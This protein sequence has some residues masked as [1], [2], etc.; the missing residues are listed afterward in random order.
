MG[1]KAEI[2]ELYSTLPLLN[3]KEN[4]ESSYLAAGI[5]IDTPPIWRL[6]DYPGY[7]E[8]IFKRVPVEQGSFNLDDSANCSM[9][10]PYKRYEIP[11]ILESW[12]ETTKYIAANFNKNVNVSIWSRGMHAEGY[13]AA[14]VELTKII[15]LRENILDSSLKFHGMIEDHSLK[16]GDEV[17]FVLE[18]DTAF[19]LSVG[20]DGGLLP[21]G[22]KLA[23]NDG[24]QTHVG[25]D[26][27]TTFFRKSGL[28]ITGWN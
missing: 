3:I 20:C 4:L 26:N 25:E 6:L 7:Y 15:E 17:Y 9:D 11:H 2:L 16:S 27:N 18:S 24:G 1:L 22:R 19:T 10:M 5:E 28:K 13:D 14:G 21:W 8:D 12:I 23:S